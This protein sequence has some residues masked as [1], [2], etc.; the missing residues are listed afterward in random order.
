MFQSNNS[1]TGRNVCT[2][3]YVFMANIFKSRNVVDWNDQSECE[4]DFCEALQKII[5]VRIM[6]NDLFMD[7]CRKKKFNENKYELEEGEIFQ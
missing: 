6:R 3:S 5:E 7:M 2:I 4:D 1:G